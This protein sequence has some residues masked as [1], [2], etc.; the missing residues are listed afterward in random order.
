MSTWELLDE[1]LT[2]WA[3]A[4][5]QVTLWW[6][7]DDAIEVTPALDSL[8]SLQETHHIPLALAVIPAKVKPG[9]AKRLT[10]AAG[11][12]VVQHGYAHLSHAE[13]G[14]KSS[15]FPLRRNKDEMLGETTDGWSRLET[16]KSRE[17]VFVPPWN[18]I[19]DILYPGLVDAG[20]S[21]ISAFGPRAN[22][23]AAASL[24]QVN[25]HVDIID[26]RGTR[27]FAGESKVLGDMV[28]HLSARR[29][30]KVDSSEPTGLL[31][32]HL[33]HDPACWAFLERFLSWT[34]QRETVKWVT[35]EM[36][37]RP[38]AGEDQDDGPA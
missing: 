23:H 7:D 38:W 20:F 10:N 30:G 11:V 5:K 6:R 15:E 26:W 31:T 3:K 18:R 12:S 36:A 25:T 24:K 16:F 21:G 4:G 13:E 27:G 1:E 17:K 2:A 9:L 34:D 8:L 32:H 33:V 22:K 19:T 14:Q 35:T 37:F 29:L 28:E